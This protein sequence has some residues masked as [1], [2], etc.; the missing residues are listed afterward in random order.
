MIERLAAAALCAAVVVGCT[1]ADGTS[2]EFAE[3]PNIGATRIDV[4]RPTGASSGACDE[5]PLPTVADETLIDRVAAL[6]AVGLFADRADVT[7][8]ELAAEVE[9]GVLEVWGEPV[10]ND[11]PFLDLLVADQ[12]ASRVWWYDLEADVSDGNDV[13]IDTLEGWADISVGAFA[14]E[15]IVETWGGD[16]GPVEVTFKQDGA[17]HALMPA[18]LEDWID[19]GMVVPI[20]DLIAASG[21][22]FELYKA[23]DQTAFV[24]ALA[25]AERQALEARGWCFE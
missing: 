16:E 19:P 5:D 22:R 15:D 2:D 8:A 4:P 13:Y 6:R 7:D 24:M 1:G 14:P 3:I 17:T 9:A 11:D 18:Y 10:A 20:N 25:D 23:F 12:D 21:R